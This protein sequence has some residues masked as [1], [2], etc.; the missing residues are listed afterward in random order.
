MCK[1]II[2]GIT[3]PL[4]VVL[5]KGQLKYFSLQGYTV[6]LLAPQT[7]DTIEFCR[8]ENAVLL[9]VEIDREINFLSD[10]KAL[11]KIYQYFKKIKPDVINVGTPKMGLLGSIAGW[12]ARVPKRI[13]TC[14]GFRFE[15][16][17]G[18]RRK[19]LKSLDKLAINLSHFVINISFSVENLGVSEG[20]FSKDKSVV[21]GKGSS[22]GLDLDFFDPFQYSIDFINK[23]KSQICS[24]NI[25]IFGFA[26]R[27][28]DRKGVNEL[29]QAFSIINRE[30][31]LT[32]LLIVGKANLE[33]VADKTL[34]LRMESDP[35]VSLTGYI[36]NVNDYMAIMDVFVL[37]AWWE[38]FGNTLIQAAAMGLPIISCDVT[39]CRD[40]VKHNYNGVLIPPKNLLELKDM[41][42]SL[43]LNE[44]ER[45][46]LGENG[47]EWA[48]LF[49]SKVIWSEMKVL[50]EG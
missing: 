2:I 36:A 3:A 27:I 38:G 26:G 41:M 35:N 23:L 16:E 37:P 20:M 22:N 42:L 4:S 30:Y 25:F 13:Y 7:S 15:H 18:I 48:K 17:T 19:L 1:R 5:L 45:R 29:Y 24:N 21:F 11:F 44:K 46:R 9:P 32:H 31:P 47:K 6:Y 39:G 50:Y 34:M 8:V 43:M 28:V 12:F 14:R 10:M 40:A 49:D 33:Q